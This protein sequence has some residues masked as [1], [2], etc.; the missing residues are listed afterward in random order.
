MYLKADS[1]QIMNK[2]FRASIEIA[3]FDV[4][5]EEMLTSESRLP[6]VLEWRTLIC[7]I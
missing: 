2:W 5:V 6:G 1:K 7:M 4:D 3:P